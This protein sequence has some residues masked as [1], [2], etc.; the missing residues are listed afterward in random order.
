MMACRGVG[1]AGRQSGLM[2]WVGENRGR[3][4]AVVAVV[5][6][7]VA[8]ASF[9]GFGP[10]SDAAAVPL[11]GEPEAPLA[12]VAD[13]SAAGCLCASGGVC[14]G[15]RGGKYCTTDAGKKRYL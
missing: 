11:V 13:S 3:A 6:I 4:A 9:V 7:V 15:P 5:L 8:G 10:S 1:Y 2:G 12:G 14:V